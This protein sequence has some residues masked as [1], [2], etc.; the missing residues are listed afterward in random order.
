MPNLEISG[1]HTTEP[2]IT[3]LL[4][5]DSLSRTLSVYSSNL[6]TGSITRWPGPLGHLL[7]LAPWE[8]LWSVDWGGKHSVLVYRCF[9]TMWWHHSAVDGCSVSVLRAG[10]EGQQEGEFIPMGRTSSSVFD[11]SLCT[12]A[13]TQVYVYID[14]WAVVNNWAGWSGTYGIIACG[15]AHY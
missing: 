13:W 6:W 5:S 9:H 12:R 14:L 2:P 1:D 3:S 15:S 7:W 4:L 10:K 8:F 11:H